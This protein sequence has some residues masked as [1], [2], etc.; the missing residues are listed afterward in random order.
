M[1]PF[2]AE[3]LN[4]SRLVEGISN[5]FLS[6]QGMPTSIF[7]SRT[8]DK[9]SRVSSDLGDFGISDSAIQ[10]ARQNFSE[11]L[12]ANVPVANVNGFVMPIVPPI[13]PPIALKI[14]SS[15]QS[16]TRSLSSDAESLPVMCGE[17]NLVP[18]SS[19]RLASPYFPANYPDN[20]SCRWSITA[21]AGEKV[22]VRC[23]QFSL[24]RGDYLALGVEGDPASLNRYTATN[25]LTLNILPSNEVFVSFFSDGD[26]PSQGFSC[27]VSSIGVEE[28]TGT[29]SLQSPTQSVTA[30]NTSVTATLSHPE[31]GLV[32]RVA[33][34]T[35]D[36]ITGRVAD[37]TSRWKLVQE[38][39]AG[40]TFERIVNGQETEAHEYPW[41]VYLRIVW[42]TGAVSG[43]GGSVISERWVLT[44]AHCVMKN[45][46][47]SIPRVVV[48][49][50][51]YNLA[52]TLDAS[53]V[54]MEASNVI[55]YPTLSFSYDLALIQ[56]PRPLTFTT[57]LRPICLPRAE[58]QNW[59][60]TRQPLVV[61]GWG[62]TETGVQ[63]TTPREL[64]QE[65]MDWQSCQRVYGQYVTEHHFCTTTNYGGH[66][67]LVG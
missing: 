5:P 30:T 54:V 36:K 38:I 56:L 2:F 35:S 32:N 15:I 46:D 66:I 50:G 47:T 63:P 9:I 10:A 64:M 16:Q 39:N 51:V 25:N 21:V 41:Q 65:G 42:Q 57:N 17:Y 24:G 55:I 67:C 48:Y 18:E 4:G 12:W 34:S 59:N 13:V 62:L 28:V 6:H 58:M 52:N 40:K 37:Q 22:G 27:T 1:S 11:D 7:H 45:G 3:A 49:A 14:S 53:R 20:F 29:L 43:C 60:M 31:C 8:A 33:G 19:L 44:A 23:H 61:V 26:T